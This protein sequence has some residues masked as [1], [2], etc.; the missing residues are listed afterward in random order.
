MKNAIRNFSSSLGDSFRLVQGNARAILFS[1]AIWAVTYSLYF[2]FLTLYMLDLGCTN[3]QVGLINA[4]GML[5]GVV[6]AV[7]AGWL[8]D[9][10]GRRLTCVIAD[11]VCWAVSC[12][13]W[14]LASN[15]AWFI[16]AA[17]ANAFVRLIAVSWNC[18]LNEGTLPEHRLN[19]YWWINI[20]GTLATFATPLMSLFIK[21]FGLVPV[22][23]G[24]MLVSSVL[25]TAGFLLRYSMMKELPI[26][27][28][29]MEA[30][31]RENPFTAVKAYWPMVKMLVASPLLLIYITMRSLFYVQAGLKSTFLPITVVQGLGFSDGIIG[32]IN[33]VTGVVMLLA[34]FLLL[35]RLRSLP[36]EKA[37]LFSI[38]TL[39]VSMLML[40]FSPAYSMFLLMASTVLAAAG[41]LVTALL[42]DTAMANALPDEGRAPLLALMTILM[43]ALSAPFML[44]GGYLAG[45]PGVGPRLPMAMITILFAV[46]LVLLGLNGKYKKRTPSAT[47]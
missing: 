1:Q 29:R 25:L 35:P 23:R 27:R 28:E 32:V 15:F 43:V 37:L 34:Q 11:T 30:A 18:S 17:I 9:R 46:C 38:S 13:L 39:I 36:A 20:V 7:F 24:V 19:T 42:V 41:S 26:G 6:V 2:P 10:L 44:L 31:R 5:A 12:V 22:M 16:A 40:V 3:Q 21:P 45:L 14:G 8:T 33:L 4:V 47:T